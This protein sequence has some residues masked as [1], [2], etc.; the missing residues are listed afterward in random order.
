[1]FFKSEKRDKKA[2]A[3]FQRKIIALDGKCMNLNCPCHRLLYSILSAHH[4]KYKS[5]GG[6]N[7]VENGITLCVLS[8]KKVHEGGYVR[9][10]K[11]KLSWHRGYEIML[12]ILEDH[13]E[14]Y[15]DRWKKSREYLRDIIN[16]KAKEKP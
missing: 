3:E 15:Y 8:N 11:G 7:V 6:L 14:T 5:Q 2:D 4:I 10:D 12:K 1:M 13:R 16:R 9:N